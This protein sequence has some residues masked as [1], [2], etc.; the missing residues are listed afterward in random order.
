MKVLAAFAA[1]LVC[2]LYGGAF[3]LERIFPPAPTTTLRGVTYG[4]TAWSAT[5]P[6]T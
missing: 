4:T 6:A 3:F 2:G 5:T 1:G